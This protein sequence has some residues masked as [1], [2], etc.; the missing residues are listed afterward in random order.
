LNNQENFKFG[1]EKGCHIDHLNHNFALT[2]ESIS[3]SFS[4]MTLMI[5]DKMQSQE[6]E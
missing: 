2:K 4:Y 1:V 6:E 3:L 5:R